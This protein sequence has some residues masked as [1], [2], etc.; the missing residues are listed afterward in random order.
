MKQLEAFNPNNQAVA[1]GVKKPPKVTLNDIMQEI[2]DIKTR[3][4]N[5]VKKNNL[6]E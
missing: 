1:F 6:V 3:L 4:D 2:K 5:I